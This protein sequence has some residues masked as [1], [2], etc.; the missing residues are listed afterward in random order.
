MTEC[1]TLLPYPRDM[2]DG[3]MVQV[4]AVE[5]RYILVAVNAADAAHFYREL[6]RH[7]EASYDLDPREKF[8]V[9]YSLDKFS[10]QELDCVAEKL[11]RWIEEWLDNN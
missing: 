11:R 1:V 10:I 6:S 7:L 3:A 9:Y 2:S 8:R 5:A 4:E